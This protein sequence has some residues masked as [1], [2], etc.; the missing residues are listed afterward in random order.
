M[1]SAF[2]IQSTIRNGHLVISTKG[3]INLEAG[4]A[5]AKDAYSYIDNGI[6]KI[7]LNMEDSR[8]INSIGISVLIEIM[9]RLD[10]VGG[11]LFFANLSPT[12]E[13]TFTIM[14]LFKYAQKADS[15]ID[16]TG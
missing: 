1:S 15:V 6:T 5:I 3:Y 9:E 11:T 14:G 12:I 8:V 4:E 13:K 2:S 16:I 10:E 7:V